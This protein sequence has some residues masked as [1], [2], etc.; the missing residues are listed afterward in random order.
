MPL[1]VIM[2]LWGGGTAPEGASAMTVTELVVS[3]ASATQSAQV[4]LGL[5]EAKMVGAFLDAGFTS[6]S[7]ASIARIGLK[8]LIAS[9]FKAKKVQA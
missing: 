4:K 9:A 3:T 7:T 5:A 6:G 8:V 2:R 1:Y